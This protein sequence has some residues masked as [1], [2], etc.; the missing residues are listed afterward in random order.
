MAPWAQAKTSSSKILE[1]EFGYLDMDLMLH[2]S[3]LQTIR[4]L[5]LKCPATSTALNDFDEILAFNLKDNKGQSYR[6]LEKTIA[7]NPGR[8]LQ[9]TL[10]SH[11][12]I[13]RIEIPIK[14]S[15]SSQSFTPEQV[16][17]ARAFLKEASSFRPI[18]KS[19]FKGYANI[20][21]IVEFFE[22]P[23]GP[24]SLLVRPRLSGLKVLSFAYKSEE[25][26]KLLKTL[27]LP[28][29]PG[30]FYIDKDNK[31]GSVEQID[32]LELRIQTETLTQRYQ[33]R[34]N[35]LLQLSDGTKLPD[36]QQHFGFMAT[37]HEGGQSGDHQCCGHYAPPII[38]GAWPDKP[39]FTN[40]PDDSSAKHDN[41]FDKCCHDVITA[42]N[43]ASLDSSDIHPKL[44]GE[45]ALLGN[46]LVAGSH[47]LA[48]F[49]PIRGL[50]PSPEEVLWL[51]NKAVVAKVRLGKTNR[52]SYLFFR[53]D[54][55][56]QL[57][58]VRTPCETSE[59][60]YP[61]KEMD[62]SLAAWFKSYKGE[63]HELETLLQEATDINWKPVSAQQELDIATKCER[64]W[65]IACHA[66][67][68]FPDAL[69]WLFLRHENDKLE[70]KL[71][72]LGF[73]SAA[74]SPRTFNSTLLRASIPADG[75]Y[76]LS[77]P[78]HGCK[79]AFIVFSPKDNP[80]GISPNGFI[81]LKK[82]DPHWYLARSAS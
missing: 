67:T 51:T 65:N 81:W 46:S 74:H 49:S 75:N 76:Y 47:Y 10:N 39:I 62:Q 7:C 60:S 32:D 9:L 57:T 77:F 66:P 27:A 50:K 56:W 69:S 38:E 72:E 70:Q 42:I 30:I 3:G 14:S 6:S 61:S 5:Q 71:N 22:E 43:T 45:V 41:S 58:A 16:E 37:V 44:S 8:T 54:M 29:A 20:P 64:L 31:G 63:L 79:G 40:M 68:Y 11:G 35:Q 28:K 23:L 2:S 4:A 59:N 25:A 12:K 1:K 55:A 34:F 82:L 33:Q 73:S 36:L 26:R 19:A 78:S 53:K 24:S 52:Y 17:K 48:S 15:N 80:P 18:F 13:K 21:Q